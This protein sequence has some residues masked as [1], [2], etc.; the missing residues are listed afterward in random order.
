MPT[1]VGVAYCPSRKKEREKSRGS[2]VVLDRL[3]CGIWEK[4]PEGERK[5]VVVVV[6]GQQEEGEEEKEVIETLNL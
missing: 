6:W 5:E 2:A 1:R 4:E 3:M